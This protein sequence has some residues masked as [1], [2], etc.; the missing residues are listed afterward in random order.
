M[1][2]WIERWMDEGGMDDREMEGWMDGQKDGWMEGGRERALPMICSVTILQWE[3][4]LGGDQ[5]IGGPLAGGRS[6]FHDFEEGVDVIVLY[7][8]STR[9][10]YLVLRFSH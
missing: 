10:D 6:R 9:R 3:P 4:A 2:G 8:V 5:S 7:G 1:D